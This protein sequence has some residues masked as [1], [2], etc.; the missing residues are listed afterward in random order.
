MNMAMTMK[1]TRSPE[2]VVAAYV[3]LRAVERVELLSGTSQT[4]E[5]TQARHEL[6]WVMRELTHCSLSEIGWWIG[7]RDMATVHAGVAKVADRL[8]EDKPYRTWL[9]SLLAAILTLTEQPDLP[10]ALTIARAVIANPD[11]HG[12]EAQALALVV[13]TAAQSVIAPGLTS[14]ERLTAA[15]AVLFAGRQVRG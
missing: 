9:Q 13:V 7:G 3:T 8:M 6:M 5:I 15:Q 1:P 2:R 14:D 11:L 4:R 10:T 12:T